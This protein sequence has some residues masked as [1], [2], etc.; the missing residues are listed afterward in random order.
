[1]KVTLVASLALCLALPASAG[2]VTK[3]VALAPANGTQE[4]SVEVDKVLSLIH[5]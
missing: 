5:I 4:V 1:M 2:I 3:K